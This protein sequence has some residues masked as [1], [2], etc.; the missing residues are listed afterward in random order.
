MLVNRNIKYLC[1]IKTIVF[2]RLFYYE[3][4]IYRNQTPCFSHPKYKEG[5][6]TIRSVV[7]SSNWGLF[8]V[9]KR[10]VITVHIQS[11]EELCAL[12][13]KPIIVR[14]MYGNF[15]FWIRNKSWVPKMKIVLNIFKNF[16]LILLIGPTLIQGAFST[17]ASF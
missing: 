11:F 10:T 17:V 13:T 12:R 8:R 15:P 16:T 3:S 1:S 2:Q 5:L 4:R 9:A 6:V 14:R 7:M